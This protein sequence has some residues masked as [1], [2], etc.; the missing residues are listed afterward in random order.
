MVFCDEF[1]VQIVIIFLKNE[2]YPLRARNKAS[3]F[4]SD[5][6]IFFQIEKII[7][8]VSARAWKECLDFLKFFERSSCN[9]RAHIVSISKSQSVKKLT[10][11]TVD[12][13]FHKPKMLRQ[14]SCENSVITSYY[15]NLSYSP[16]LS[17]VHR[18]DSRCWI[19]IY[20]LWI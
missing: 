11:F 2:H 5:Y 1:F 3:F 15:F 8:F 4:K 9:N 6:V 20:W 7:R 16:R 12:L 19:K 17:L 18:E 14:F 10:N 13:I